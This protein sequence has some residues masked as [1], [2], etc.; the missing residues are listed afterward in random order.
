MA[1]IK[2]TLS[3]DGS[4]YHG[5][6]R[7]TH[8]PTVQG[9]VEAALAR[10]TQ[11]TTPIYGAGRTDAGVHA[12]G[13]VAHFLTERPFLPEDWVRGLNAL[14]PKDIAVTRAEAVDADFH[15][16][17][18]AKEKHYRY[19]IQTAAP[20]SP[21]RY[22]THWY[23]PKALDCRQMSTAAEALCGA[24]RFTSFCAAGSDAKDYLIDLKRIEIEEKA[25]R[26][27]LTFI[28]PRFLQHMVRNIVGLLV[29]VGRG[30]RSA[31]DVPPILAAEDRRIAGPTAP[32][33]GL[34]L[35][36]VIY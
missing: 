22:R 30:K 3:Y 29:E 16:R 25:D 26:I 28:A 31:K 21:F 18:S 33:Q 24:H 6:Q 11:K 5:W 13:Q 35:L 19:L 23:Y 4:A 15:A 9:Q 8:L 12:L 7:Q 27:A 32:P 20:R 17:Y 10:L 2:L 34:F 36:K 14:L 1:V